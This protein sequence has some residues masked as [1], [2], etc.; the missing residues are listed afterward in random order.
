[1]SRLN[2]I[3]TD[4]NHPL[5]HAATNGSCGSLPKLGRSCGSGLSLASHAATIH[6]STD[7]SQQKSVLNLNNCGADAGREQA[8]AVTGEQSTPITASV[9]LPL[10]VD[11]LADAYRK[12]SSVWEV[13]KQFGIS[14][15]RVHY[16]LKKSNVVKPIRVITDEERE[17]ITAYYRG[18]PPSEFN[19]AAFAKSLGRTRHL[20]CRV[21]GELGLT[22]PNRPESK[23][24]VEQLKKRAVGQ[25]D[26]TP[27]PRG[28]AGKKH[29]EKSRRLGGEASKRN[30]ATWKAF[31]LG[32][33]TPENRDKRSK[34]QSLRARSMTPART[35]TK[36]AGGRRPDLGETFFRSRWEANYARYLNLLMKM[37]VVEK[38]EFESQTFWFDGIKRGVMSYLPD[39]KVWYK[40]SP[41][42]FVEIKGWVQAKDRTKWKRMAKYHPTVKLEIVAEKEYR[43]IA[44]KWASAIPT[45]EHQKSGR[46]IVLSETRN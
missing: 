5:D 46:S 29:T 41:P 43:A 3:P 27:H 33:V 6:P 17:K 24:V 35:F 23:I 22:N 34:Q 37:G 2:P 20:V 36:A 45:W 1:M 18:C 4:R 21:A 26:K 32:P 9:L 16:L 42:V 11:Q 44:R 8:A 40:N 31:D 12:C 13:G 14:G 19:L 28:M 10:F 15:Q 38:W 7:E 30:W 39:F 25:W